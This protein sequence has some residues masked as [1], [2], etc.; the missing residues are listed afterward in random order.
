MSFEIM[1]RIDIVMLKLFDLQDGL[2]TGRAE[3]ITL[4]ADLVELVRI[5][6]EALEEGYTPE[7]AEARWQITKLLSSE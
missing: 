7:I 6:L 2:L 1:E 5:L 4:A 3:D